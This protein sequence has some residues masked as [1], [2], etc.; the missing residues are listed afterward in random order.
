MARALLLLGMTGCGIPPLSEIVGDSVVHDDTSEEETGGDTG[1]PACG[2]GV[3]PALSSTSGCITG[4]EL[5][6]EDGEPWGEAFLGV[7][8][9]AP[10][11]GPLRFLPP[12]RVADWSEPL[13]ATDPGQPCLQTYDTKDGALSDGEGDED[14]LRL[15]IWRPKDADGL[16]LLFF[17]H[18]GAFLHG[19]GAVTELAAD[20]TLAKSAVVVTHNAR[21]GPFGYLAHPAL[22]AASKLGVSGNQGVHDTIEALSW[23]NDN[24]LELGADPDRVLLV[25][26]ESGGLVA[27][28]LLMSPL[29]SGLFDAAFLQSA[30]CGWLELPLSDEVPSEEIRSAEDAGQALAAALG[31]EGSDEQVLACLQNTEPEAVLGALEARKARLTDQDGVPW[32]PN[33][34]GYVLPE[35]ARARIAAG[36]VHDVPVFAGVNADEGTI[37]ADDINASAVP[38][39]FLYF[40][41]QQLLDKNG[42]DPSSF[43]DDLYTVAAHGSAPAAYAAFYGDLLHTC[44][45]RSFLRALSSQRGEVYAYTWTHAPSFGDAE[46]GAF[47]GSELPF[48]FGTRAAEWSDEERKMSGWLQSAWLWSL[49]VEPLVI[50]VGEWPEADEDLWV[51]FGDDGEPETEEDPYGERC[52]AIDAT[53]WHAY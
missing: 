30:P 15:N 5:L 14:C 45:T 41:I 34:D 33:V 36:L 37:Y 3:L 18:G 49:E 17:I 13:A 25:G 50:E 9:A 42:T 43:P 16:P 29:A 24:A 26:Q 46:L 2:D 44:P 38:G 48:L 22:S 11:L 52:E 47:T 32:E 1:A 28:A 27:C 8:Y 51:V 40:Y 53:G 12:S 35:P 39:S 6:D 7:P 4:A 10:P 20:P 21:L 31:C 23:V 19:S